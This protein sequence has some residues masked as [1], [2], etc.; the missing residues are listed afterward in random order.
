V[1]PIIFLIIVSIGARFAGEKAAQYGV[2]LHSRLRA[3]FFASLQVQPTS[4]EQHVSLTFGMLITAA[5]IYLGTDNN[6]FQAQQ[7]IAILV[8]QSR[9]SGLFK[10]KRSSQNN[11]S[12]ESNGDSDFILAAWID[13]ESKKRIAFEIFRLESYLSSIANIKP[14]LSAK[15]LHIELPCSSYLWN[16]SGHD[17]KRRTIEAIE[18]LSTHRRRPFSDLVE[19]FIDGCEIGQQLNVE[20]LERLLLAVQEKLWCFCENQGL[21]SHLE[22][23]FPPSTLSGEESGDI[24]H[25]PVRTFTTL[26]SNFD[27]SISALK[28]WEKT[29]SQCLQLSNSRSE[30]E[31]Y[32]RGQIEFHTTFIRLNTPLDTLSQIA[33]GS[34]DPQDLLDIHTWRQSFRARTAMEHSQKLWSVVKQNSESI[35]G[36]PTRF[37]LVYLIALH[38]AALVVWAWT[39]AGEKYLDETD[40]YPTPMFDGRCLVKENSRQIVEG[41]KKLIGDMS[42]SWFGPTLFVTVID[43]IIATEF[44]AFQ[45]S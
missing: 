24:F 28:K 21:W 16:M 2:M 44:P 39:G 30:H 25:M 14:L 38:H 3:L 7:L 34:R 13:A 9:R 29:S 19:L 35:V 42:P 43:T 17:W 5:E 27:Q 10:A 20:D 23:E 45:E 1:S 37:D 11:I 18:Q 26:R 15:E 32:V 36:I 6:F 33:S 41:F 4:D 12:D 22:E 8:T 40:V 31:I